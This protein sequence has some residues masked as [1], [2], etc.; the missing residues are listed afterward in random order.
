MQKNKAGLI[1]AVVVVLVIAVYFSFRK[2]SEV[3]VETSPGSQT[4][5]LPQAPGVNLTAQSHEVQKGE[6]LAFSPGQLGAAAS[7]PS[8][9]WFSLE[10][11][12]GFSTYVGIQPGPDG[13]I[14]IG[15]A[16]PAS[17]SHPGVQDG[18]E[19][20]SVD[21][22]WVFFGS[23]GMHFTVGD[24]IKFISSGQLDFSSWRWTW[25][26]AQEINLGAGKTASFIW[27]GEPGQPFTL[28]YQAI[29]PS[30]TP[31]FGG[32]KYTLHLEGDVKRSGS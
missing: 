18:K 23:T 6:I 3:R 10:L 16:Q 25:N 32:K 2:S 9:S 12:T 8:G 19:M 29:F 5:V 1:I 7:P 26:G 17:G 21:T 4:A 27:S 31:G 24:G 30:D 14:V 20:A 13:G 11:V 15:K 28:E 22:P